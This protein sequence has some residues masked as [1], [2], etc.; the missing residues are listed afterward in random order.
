MPFLITTVGKTKHE[1]CPGK[2]VMVEP[3]E[4]AQLQCKEEMKG[5]L[6]TAYFIAQNK[7]AFWLNL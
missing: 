1:A 4:Q 5:L 7:C 6:K 3:V 2:N